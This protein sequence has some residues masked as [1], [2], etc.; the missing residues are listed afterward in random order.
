MPKEHLFAL[1]STE[2]DLL[3]RKTGHI[4]I[5]SSYIHKTRDWI[6]TPFRDIHSQMKC[7]GFLMKAP[8][9]F[10]AESFLHASKWAV[11]YS[12]AWATIS[13]YN[14]KVRVRMKQRSD[15]SICAHRNAGCRLVHP[16]G[17]SRLLYSDQQVSANWLGDYSCIHHTWQMLKPLE[18]HRSK[19]KKAVRNKI[20]TTG[21]REAGPN[22]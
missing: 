5:K 6:K 20:R 14:W 11:H 12:L 16:W 9:V 1:Q 21:F 3:W 17:E 19:L 15:G 18:S 4:Q 22:S 2:S 7:C 8:H 13:F 10:R